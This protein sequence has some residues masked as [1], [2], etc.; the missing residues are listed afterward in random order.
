MEILPELLD[1]LEIA[2]QIFGP[3][4]PECHDNVT[5]S[6][7]TLREDTGEVAPLHSHAKKSCSRL[8][9]FLHFSDKNFTEF[10]FYSLFFL[11]NEQE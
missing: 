4:S 11:V 2:S 1:L 10:S 5:T 9:N 3:L 7:K 6:G 8:D